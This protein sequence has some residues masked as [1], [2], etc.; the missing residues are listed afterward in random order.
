MV[1]DIYLIYGMIF[2]DCNWVST[3]WKWSVDIYKNRKAKAQKESTQNNTKIQ[4]HKIVN[5]NTKQKTN[6]KRIF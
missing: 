4:K 3:L 5:K 6:I 2:I 1:Y